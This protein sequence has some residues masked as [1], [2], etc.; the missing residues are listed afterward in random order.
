MYRHQ[1]QACLWCH[2]SGIKKGVTHSHIMIRVHHSQK[3]PFST[4]TECEQKALGHTALVG[5]DHLIS[6]QGLKQLRDNSLRV[7]NVQKGKVTERVP[8]NLE[9]RVTL[10][11]H[12]HAQVAPLVMK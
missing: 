3:K 5:N 9:A 6:I 1:H 4:S 7:A 11:Q 8:G 2:G 10:T 12:Y